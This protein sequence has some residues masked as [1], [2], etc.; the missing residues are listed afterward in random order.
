VAHRAGARRVLLV[1]SGAVY[2]TQP[3]ALSHVDEAY[4]GGPDPLDAANAYA[5]G[6]RASELL[7]ALAARDAGGLEVTVARCF[8]F[9]GPHLPLDAHFAIGNFIRDA[10]AG[11]PIRLSGD[12]TPVRSYLYAGDL[13]AWLW[14][15]LVRGANGRAYNV[16]SERAL[17]LWDVAQ[18]VARAAGLDADAVIRAREP[19]AGATAPRY[20]PAVRRARGELA[21]DEWTSLDVGITRTLAWADPSRA[22]GETGGGA[23]RPGCAVLGS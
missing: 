4:A 17:P 7:G 11:G 3:P 21:L 22:V 16:G 5:E 19:A 23:G 1:S 8:A 2:G 18:I 9:V 6:K 20:A 12:G 15:A 10:L 13:A 14:A